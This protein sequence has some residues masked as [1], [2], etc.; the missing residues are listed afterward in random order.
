MDGVDPQVMLDP[1][2]DVA[3]FGFFKLGSAPDLKGCPVCN[4][5]VHQAPEDAERLR[6]V[7]SH[8]PAA[9]LIK[10]I[11]NAMM[12]EDGPGRDAVEMFL[13]QEVPEFMD[14]FEALVNKIE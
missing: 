5:L 10:T 11:G 9:C 1:D 6:A 2:T 12:I 13:N 4:E 14:R 8:P 7:L 3:D